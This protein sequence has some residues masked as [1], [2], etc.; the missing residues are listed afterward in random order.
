[1]RRWGVGVGTVVAVAV[2]VVVLSI[3]GP[4][5]VA[6]ADPAGPTDFRSEILSIEPPTPTIALAVLGGDSFVQLTVEEGTEV[7]VIGYR[8]EPYLWFRPDGTVLE[9]RLSPTTY[10]NVDRYGTEVPDTADPE[11]DPEWRE[12]GA[13]GRWSWHD[14]RAHLMQSVPPFGTVPGDRIL[15]SVVPLIVDGVEVD[16]TVVSTWEP[17]PSGVPLWIGGAIGAVLAS[18]A[19]VVVMRHGPLGAV[20]LL[21]ALLG[22]FIGYWQYSSLPS[23]TGPQLTW[24][25]LPLVAGVA[26]ACGLASFVRNDRVVGPALMLVAGTLL[27]VWAGLRRDGLTAAIVPTGAPN[28]LDRGTT[29]LVMIAGAGGVVAAIVQLATTW[30]SSGTDRTREAT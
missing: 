20:L 9:N 7:E 4:A 12:V 1:L 6:F 10:L 15:E 24:W 27:V 26:A 30:L 17:E 8:G 21:P 23:E 18:L 29:L 13:E 16:V 22:A 28:G 2:A 11:A 3:L 25:V 19:L 14:H 5:G